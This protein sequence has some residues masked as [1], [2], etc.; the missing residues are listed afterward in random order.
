MRLHTASVAR[1]IDLNVVVVVLSLVRRYFPRY[2]VVYDIAGAHALDLRSLSLSLSPLLPMHD[3]HGVILAHGDLVLVPARIVGTS[4]Q[5]EFCNVV[6]ETLVPM[7]P[8]TAFTTISLNARQL[9]KAGSGYAVADRVLS[10]LTEAGE[11]LPL[12]LDMVAES[13]ENAPTDS[14][15][16]E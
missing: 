12:D 14:E 3:R 4:T 5:D 6:V 10:A 13:N 7:Y 15:G 2:R 16:A 8:T 9:E 1:A 11:P